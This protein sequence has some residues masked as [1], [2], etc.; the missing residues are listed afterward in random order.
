MENH[1]TSNQISK[2]NAHLLKILEGQDI[3]NNKFELFDTSKIASLKKDL[4][5]SSR[6]LLDSLNVQNSLS[7]HISKCIETANNDVTTLIEKVP[8]KIPRPLELHISKDSTPVLIK[9][10]VAVFSLAVLFWGSFKWIEHA[11]FYPYKIAWEETYERIPDEGKELL[12]SYWLE[13]IGEDTY[14]PDITE[15]ISRSNRK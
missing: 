12:G 3:I 5:S 8:V 11:F 13:L 4:N 2:L 1:I 15:K 6:L 10:F 7:E 9:T 14:V